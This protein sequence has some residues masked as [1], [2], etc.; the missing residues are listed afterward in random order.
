MLW[1]LYGDE[2]EKIADIDEGLGRNAF[3][4]YLLIGSQAILLRVPQHDSRTFPIPLS[5]VN[6]SYAE[7]F[8]TS[9]EIEMR[10]SLVK[11]LEIN[12]FTKPYSFDLAISWEKIDAE[13]I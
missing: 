8:F 6:L 12:S 5:K 9:L 13:T 10:L 3:D 7:I 2:R 4:L 1:H 11:G